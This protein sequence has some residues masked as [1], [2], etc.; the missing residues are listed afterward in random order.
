[1]P[2]AGHG[3]ACPSARTCRRFRYRRLNI[4]LR[5]EGEASG[6]NRIYRLYREEGLA[7]RKRR[8]RRKAVGTCAPILV[9]AKPNV[10]TYRIFRTFRTDVS[11]VLIPPFMGV[12]DGRLC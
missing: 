9:E 7:V 2:A 4:L 8:T 3:T 11:A 5:D 6:I 10:I 12:C 1:M